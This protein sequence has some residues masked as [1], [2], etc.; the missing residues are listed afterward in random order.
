LERIAEKCE[1]E[2]HDI[3]R[4]LDAVARALKLRPDEAHLADEVERL[5]RAVGH[6]DQAGDILETVIG[7]G[8][9]EP[10]LRDLG[11]RA[12]RLWLRLSLPDR[13]EQRFLAVLS[14]EKDN[15]EA[16]S[17]LEQI[18]RQRNDP[19]RLAEILER[20]AEEEFDVGGKKQLYAEAANLHAGPLADR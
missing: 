13:A 16:L 1:R 19:A 3:T 10:V 20:R 5:G 18:Y 12:A 7:Q 14:L 11:L 6:E 4:A 15:A 8:A 2:I 9:P 17:A